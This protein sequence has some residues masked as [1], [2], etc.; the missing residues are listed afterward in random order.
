MTVDH[1][2]QQLAG[3]RSTGKGT[4]IAQCPAHGDKHPSLA[5]REL[6]DGRVL[7]HCFVGCSAGDVVAVLGMTLSDLFPPRTDGSI[8]HRQRSE[9]RPFPATDALRCI[10][11]EAMLVLISATRLARGATLT[12]GDRQRLLVAASRIQAAVDAVGAAT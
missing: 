7:L 3:V 1:L 11:V 8:D 9:R 12:E 10:A 5:I 4:W 6:D 2:L